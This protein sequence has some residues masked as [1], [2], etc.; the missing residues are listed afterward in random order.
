MADQEWLPP[1][2]GGKGSDAFWR[3]QRDDS[4]GTLYQASLAYHAHSCIASLVMGAKA[5]MHLHHGVTLSLILA[6]DA[7][8]FRRIGAV[9]MLLHDFPDIFSALIKG[10]IAAKHTLGTVVAYVGVLLSWGYCRLYLFSLVGNGRGMRAVRAVANYWLATSAVH[11]ALTPFS[12]F[13]L[14]PLF[15]VPPILSLF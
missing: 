8:G 7:F 15:F 12:S 6:S 4:L 1:F 2:L 10:F 13:P 9:V 14:S 5:E 3:P 11:G